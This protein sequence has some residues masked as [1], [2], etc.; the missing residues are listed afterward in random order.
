MNY[1]KLINFG[2]GISAV[3][4]DLILLKFYF[5]FTIVTVSVNMGRMLF[6]LRTAEEIK[7]LQVI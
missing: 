2:W 1:F 4:C 6:V 7:L 3:F 5:D